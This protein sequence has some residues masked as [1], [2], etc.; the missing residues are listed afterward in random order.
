MK[1]FVL[2]L[3]FVL[4]CIPIL[5]QTSAAPKSRNS[6]IF[7]VVPKA[8][9]QL[10]TT[11]VRERSCFPGHLGLALKFTFRNVGEEPVIV[12][13]RS[14]IE[15]AFVSR[16]L[17]AASV[18]KYEQEIRADQYDGSY[19]DL[20]DMSTFVIIRPGESYDLENSQTR[21]S[22]SVDQGTPRTK[23]GLHTGSYFLQVEVATWFYFADATQSQRKWRD[24]GYLWSE[25]LTS[26][27]MPFT[28]EPNRPIVKCS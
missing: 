16:T 7:C 10:T 14:F 4:G 18:R 20:P 13:K 15:R 1:P 9:L 25:G 28:V 3:A 8:R 23:D 11:V 26:Q 19:F 21:V 6:N 2:V 17:K 27:P 12:D 22:L 24:K 5:E